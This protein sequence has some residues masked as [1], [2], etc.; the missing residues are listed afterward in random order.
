M[1][2]TARAR[3]TDLAAGHG[4]TIALSILAAATTWLTLTAWRGFVEE[5]SSYLGRLALLAL[6]VA[7][8]G[9]VLRSTSLARPLVALVQTVVVTAL[10]SQQIAGTP[11]PLGGAS[12]EIS[13]ALTTAIDAARLYQAPV[14]AEAP[15]VW[16]L[17][18]VAGALFLL[19]VD[20]VACTYRHVPAAGLALLA[21]YSVPSGLID[22][23]PDW[24]SFVAAA[25]GFLALLHIDARGHTL[26]WG[27]MVGDPAS[28][29]GL[30]RPVRDAARASTW[31]IGVTATALALVLPTFIPVLAVDVFEFGGS[32]GNGDIRIR[33][34][35]VDMRRDLE[36]GEEVPLIRFTT[37]DP[38]P[39]YLR[40][41]VLNRFTGDEWSS[42]DRDVDGDNLADGELP[43]PPGL[44][45]TVPVREYRYDL[46]ISEDLDSTWL[47]TTFP[48]K[49]VYAA[50]DWRYDP[51]TL[52]FLS[53]D[54]DLDTKRM[55]YSVTSL[56]PDYGA[57]G[58][59]FGDAASGAVPDELL[60]A[61][62]VSNAVRDLARA[63]TEAG[64]NDYERATL[65]QRWFR[66]D[67]GFTY[68]LRAA[69]NGTGNDTLDHFLSAEGRVG[70][71]EQFA[72]AMA[73]MARSLGIPARV[74][75]GFLKPTNYTDGTWEYTS[76]DLHAWPELYFADAG[77]VRF[78]P[79]PADR[80]PDVPPYS[81]SDID[82]G[83][84]PEPSAPTTS[85]SASS[86]G[87]DPTAPE[88]RPEQ[89]RAEPDTTAD[90]AAAQ[91]DGGIH[92]LVVVACLIAALL[93]LLLLIGP[94]LL[95]GRH[96]R[97]GLHGGPEEIWTE[98]RATVRDLGASWPE[99]RSPREVGVVLAG[100]LGDPTA[101]PDPD[102][103][104]P[105][106]GPSAAPAA[107]DALERIVDRVER[108]RYARDGSPAAGGVATLAPPSLADDA[109][110]VITALEAGVTARARRRA[111]WMPRSIWRH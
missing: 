14:S 107:A 67:G 34:P 110:L 79:T 72:S 6:V 104:R 61:P 10:V 54:D 65:L 22:A 69:P 8:L 57:D 12:A 63:V 56:D 41:A 42:G 32:G 103:E 106:T 85:A 83:G 46:T 15:P 92:P 19:I 52:D 98:L 76:H 75:V 87:S 93:V 109:H 16:P 45:S 35:L 81:R 48:A 89:D 91:E 2:G 18:V 94:P 62:G 13:N 80:A 40:L 31:T 43:R 29:N 55:Q 1:A 66:E 111:R 26:V 105:R 38:S 17:I 5:P 20:T 24:R 86:G 74:A 101:P 96:R 33:K 50:G 78:E 39:S 82:S 23:G 37:D 25:A 3:R 71:C 49:A 53:A 73:V 100:Q 21:I 4:T 90:D 99:G 84:F 11:I 97:A 30:A 108:T 59:W 28:R 60:D 9:A 58:R 36:R 95:R 70:Y 44:S 68:D 47:P 51:T 77:W 88:R 102:I 27:R 64:G 7:A